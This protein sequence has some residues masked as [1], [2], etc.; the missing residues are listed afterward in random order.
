MTEQSVIMNNLNKGTETINNGLTT[1]TNNVKSIT[2]SLE[3]IKSS[4][5]N[6]LND[7]S[8]KGTLSASQE[9]LNSNSIIAKFVFLILIL[10]AFMFLVS[11][12]TSLIAYFYKPNRSPYLIRGMISGTTPITIPQDPNNSDS[13]TIYRSNNRNNGI[14]F[15]W[16]VWLFINNI[17]TTS[18][19]NEEYKH[20]FNKGNN[21]F[22]TS[23]TDPDKGIASVNNAPGLYLSSKSN[24]LRVIMDQVIINAEPNVPN[25][26]YI[27]IENIPINK[28]VNVIIRLKNN[29]IDVY[30]NGT[31]S[32]TKQTTHVPKQNYNNVNIC[33]NNGFAGYLSDLRYFD[34]DL[35]VFE[36]NNIVLAGPNTNA[37][38]SASNPT[39]LTGFPYYLSNMWYTSKQ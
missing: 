19:M 31:V 1:V 12:G 16:S 6:A 29:L 14:E 37:S 15:T 13:I 21:T 17:N 36:I 10:I 7:F 27:D 34:H 24:K 25:R 11:L 26:E 23:G 3:G 33:Q 39:S 2:N 20:I 28:W 22:I 4:V 8:S 18:S 38:S 30:I 35:N 9:F 5:G 32:A